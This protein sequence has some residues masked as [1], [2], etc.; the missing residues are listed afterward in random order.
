MESMAQRAVLDGRSLCSLCS[1]RVSDSAALCAECG[2]PFEGSYAALSCPFCGSVTPSG[3]ACSI[4]GS[5]LPNA[6]E[7]PLPASWTAGEVEAV[8]KKKDRRSEVRPATPPPLDLA[9]RSNPEPTRSSGH[10]RTNAPAGPQG[11]QKTPQTPRPPETRSATAIKPLPPNSD[12]I[13][14][15]PQIPSVSKSP[16]VARDPSLVDIETSHM[17]QKLVNLLLRINTVAAKRDLLAL[18]E[19]CIAVTM[20]LEISGIRPPTDENEPLVSRKR[21]EEVAKRLRETDA[22]KSELEMKVKEQETQ[23]AKMQEL[24]A[25][26][27]HHRATA[28]LLADDT[29][30]E[31]GLAIVLRRLRTGLSSSWKVLESGDKA[32]RAKALKIL[33]KLME[34]VD[35]VVGKEE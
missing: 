10:S 5:D 19:A 25:S 35:E 13:A 9:R 14:S 21:V 24:V 27:Q 29:Y 15:S 23:L 28:D 18:R 16:L 32:E 34:Q 2:S 33:E 20:V 8:P 31:E 4:C 17:E 7:S 26:A 22:K 6:G 1:A 12:R 30:T 3:P 11:P